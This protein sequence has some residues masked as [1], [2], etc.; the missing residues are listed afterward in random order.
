MKHIKL[1]EDFISDL[2]Q[3]IERNL[4]PVP[5]LDAYVT[6]N[7]IGPDH[8]NLNDIENIIKKLGKLWRL[9]DSDEIMYIAKNQDELDMLPE[10]PKD[11]S[12]K[13]MSHHEFWTREVIDGGHMLY[14]S[15]GKIKSTGNPNWLFSAILLK[16]FTQDEKIKYRG[17]K[18]ARKFNL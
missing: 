4:I 14:F 13:E 3:S 12:S 7:K 10:Y 6:R 18:S 2:T 15:Y 1:F 8:Q 17:T 9:P 16:D 11:S 5:A